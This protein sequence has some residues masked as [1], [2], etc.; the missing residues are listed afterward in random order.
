MIIDVPAARG[1]DAPRILGDWLR[2]VALDWNA[3][4]RRRSLEGKPP[5]EP[6][7][8]GARTEPRP[9]GITRG[10]LGRLG[11]LPPPPEPDGDRPAHQARQEGE[12][13]VADEQER[14]MIRG[15][16]KGGLPAVDGYHRGEK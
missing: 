6:R 3:R 1:P 4:A 14:V 13:A 16:R 9:P 2:T 12:E 5:G 10:E 15:P 7:M 11:P 8:G